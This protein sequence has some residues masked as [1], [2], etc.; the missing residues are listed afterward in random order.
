MVSQYSSCFSG[1]FGHAVHQ[2]LRVAGNDGDGGLQIVGQV[3]HQICG[4]LLLPDPLGQLGL[5]LPVGPLQ[6]VN[7]L[8]QRIGHGVNA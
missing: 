2:R 3:G 1:V 7:M 6:R 5:E 4:G 8:L